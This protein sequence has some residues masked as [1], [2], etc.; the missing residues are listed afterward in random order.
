MWNAAHARTSIGD[1]FRIDPRDATIIQCVHAPSWWCKSDEDDTVV[2]TATGST[3]LFPTASHEITLRVLAVRSVS[4]ND[5]H[6]SCG[7]G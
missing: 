3:L 1:A 5:K 2:R 7:S 6:I 4:D